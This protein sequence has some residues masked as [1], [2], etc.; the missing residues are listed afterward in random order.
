MIPVSIV[1][2]WLYFIYSDD[3]L[4]LFNVWKAR[5]TSIVTSAAFQQS[6]AVQ[7]RSFVA[8]G[9]LAGSDLEDDFMYQILVALKA[10][11]QR[12]DESTTIAIVSMLRCICKL[13]PALNGVSTNGEPG[14]SRYPCSLF[15]LAVAL[16]M[17]S[18]A[19]FYV[20]ANWLLR[21]ALDIM[22]ADKMFDDC[23]VDIA[24]FNGRD[25]LDAT[26]VELDEFLRLDFE[27]N[28]S[29]ALASIIFKGIRH[30]L[31][32]DSAE[33]VLRSLVKATLSRYKA[34]T[35]PA[36]NGHTPVP[37][38]EVIGYLL[39]LLPVSTK[40]ADYR[41]LLLDCH[42][43][44]EYIPDA[45][46]DDEEDETLTLSIEML[47]VNDSSTALL[48]ASFAGTILMNAQGDDVETQI[49]YS[50]LASI[51]ET[52]PEVISIVYVPSFD[53]CLIHTA[54]IFV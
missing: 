41:R 4:G 5:W 13:M 49:L 54:D 48:V 14:P 51:A 35:L 46:D 29:I 10:A 26:L 9:I 38:L 50:L 39:A 2:D 22:V 31:F 45:Q 36:V 53:I 21:V 44:S 47:G 20:E 33:T 23:P 43:G 52:Y 27:V 11:F 24:L 7:T 1:G 40:P 19:A 8:L 6:P 18:H 42:I 37:C 16:L 32:K 12:A 34:N 25:Q 3:K 30:T 17:S 28:F 15:W